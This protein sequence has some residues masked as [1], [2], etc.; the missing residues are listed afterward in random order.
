[1]DFFFLKGW[2]V[3]IIICFVFNLFISPYGLIVSGVIG[4]IGTFIYRDAESTRE[5]YTTLTLL[6]FP[7]A[8]Y[9]S[10]VD[11]DLVEDKVYDFHLTKTLNE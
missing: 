9:Q 7:T 4:I 11:L 1:M 8:I 2:I 3:L 10:I 5:S 6:I